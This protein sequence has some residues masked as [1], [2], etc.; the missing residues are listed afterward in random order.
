MFVKINKQ[1][2]KFSSQTPILYRQE[3]TERDT[4]NNTTAALKALDTLT[5]D[6][7]I[8]ALESCAKFTG[9]GLTEMA[10]HDPAYVLRAV[11]VFGDSEAYADA[12][13]RANY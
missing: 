11:D 4:M 6:E 3:E 8:D 10:Y 1:T 12:M 7:Y 2:L 5:A 13:N 9:M